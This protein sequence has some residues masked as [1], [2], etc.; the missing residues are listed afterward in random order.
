MKKFS[1]YDEALQQVWIILHTLSTYIPSRF[2]SIINTLPT[3]YPL[4]HVD[5]RTIV[6]VSHSW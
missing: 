6:L 1:T 2:H 5:N 3:S 4:N